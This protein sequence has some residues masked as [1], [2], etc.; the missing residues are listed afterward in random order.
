MEMTEFKFKRG[1]R[2]RKV[3]GYKF[4]GHVNGTFRYFVRADGILFNDMGK[5]PMVNVQHD[6]GWVMHFREDDLEL[7][8]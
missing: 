1:D 8:K 3:K 7:V 6:D 2:V 4:E 5:S